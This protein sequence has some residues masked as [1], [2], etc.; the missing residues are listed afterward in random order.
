MENTQ[1]IATAKAVQELF[2]EVMK[3]YWTY[4]NSLEMY[5][6]RIPDSEIGLI[7]EA[8]THIGEVLSAMEH[9]IDIFDKA[10]SDDLEATRKIKEELQ[11]DDIY[12]KL[13]S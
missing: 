1:I 11:I 8:N 10:V 2:E 5:V 7:E 3:L 6:K 9:D 12:N 4:L 13:K